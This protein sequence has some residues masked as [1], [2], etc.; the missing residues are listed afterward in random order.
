MPMT[1]WR[2]DY[3]HEEM[4]FLRDALCVKAPARRTGES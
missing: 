1:R 2:K 3:N 4:I